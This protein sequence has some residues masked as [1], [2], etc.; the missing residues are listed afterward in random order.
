MDSRA[1]IQ[2]LFPAFGSQPGY[3]Q[4]RQY[5]LRQLEEMAKSGTL[6]IT[7]IIGCGEPIKT[8]AGECILGIRRENGNMRQVGLPG[9]SKVLMGY[10]V[11]IRAIDHLVQ[12]DQTMP[13]GTI[14]SRFEMET[15]PITFRYGSQ[16][17]DESMTYQ[18]AQQSGAIHHTD[19]AQVE[20]IY[21]DTGETEVELPLDQA[22][23]CLREQGKNCA[24]AASQR[25]QNAIWKVEEIRPDAKRGPGRPRKT[26][27]AEANV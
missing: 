17:L 15:T 10:T 22:W 26:E 5:V 24:R 13:D 21:M 12:H 4:Q 20:R 19:M 27:Q 6:F 25:R 18:A 7:D 11:R 23:W 8:I 2:R 14:Q 9:I 3:P 16:P 1:L